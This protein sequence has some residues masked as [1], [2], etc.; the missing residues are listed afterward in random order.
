MD[1]LVEPETD[2]TDPPWGIWGRDFTLAV[3]A[4]GGIVLMQWLNTLQVSGG[5]SFRRKVVQRERGT[6]LFTVC[7][8]CRLPSSF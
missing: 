6:P 1:S 3:V 2:I 4:L 8:H 5:E 7:N